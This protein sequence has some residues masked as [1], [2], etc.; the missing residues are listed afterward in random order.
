M[1]EEKHH[2]Q[3]LA[4]CQLLYVMSYVFNCIYV[5]NFIQVELAISKKFS[6]FSQNKL[7]FLLIFTVHYDAAYL[8]E[9]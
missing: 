9:L 7:C 8:T 5:F 1:A 6:I 2:V 3:G 4:M